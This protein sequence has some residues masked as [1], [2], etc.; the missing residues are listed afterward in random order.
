MIVT[1]KRLRNHCSREIYFRN[2]RTPFQPRKRGRCS[3]STDLFFKEKRRT[4]TR[5]NIIADSSVR[6]PNFSRSRSCGDLEIFLSFVAI[7]PRVLE[8]IQKD[9]S[10]NSTSIVRLLYIYIKWKKLS[11]E[12]WKKKSI[13]KQLVINFDFIPS[14]NVLRFVIVRLRN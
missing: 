2:T 13:L 6:F 9:V 5:C 1:S 12:N 14:N 7:S 10:S 8:H 4:N 11:K 3:V